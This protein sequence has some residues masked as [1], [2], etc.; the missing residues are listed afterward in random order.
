MEP[1]KISSALV[2]Y[3][4]EISTNFLIT[5]VAGKKDFMQKNFSEKKC[6][7]ITETGFCKR[8]NKQCPLF[9]L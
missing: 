5:K 7:H 9:I 8:S 4:K 1:I 6:V 2:N 3:R